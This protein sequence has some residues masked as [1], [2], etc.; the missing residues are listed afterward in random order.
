MVYG[1]VMKFITLGKRYLVLIEIVKFKE[2]DHFPIDKSNY[3]NMDDWL[4][5]ESIESMKYKSFRGL[6]EICFATFLYWNVQTKESAR[7]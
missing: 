3:R 4:P 2:V 1:F 7:G 5:V 6:V